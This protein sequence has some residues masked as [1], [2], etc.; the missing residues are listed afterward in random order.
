MIKGPAGGFS[1]GLFLFNE[2]G[3]EKDAMET[4]ETGKRERLRRLAEG[5]FKGLILA[6]AQDSI[7]VA[8]APFVLNWLLKRAGFGT[9]FGWCPFFLCWLCLRMAVRKRFALLGFTT[10]GVRWAFGMEKEERDRL[11]AKGCRSV[12]WWLAAVLVSPFSVN[13]L[14][15]RAGMVPLPYFEG[16]KIVLALFWL[17]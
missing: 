17:C 9:D 14:L 6:V 3:K 1:A 16:I 13:C 12:F 8:T 10:G 15:S 7:K 2:A 11:F 4:N 5:A